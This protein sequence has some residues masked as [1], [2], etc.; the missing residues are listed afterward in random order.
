M[1]RIRQIEASAEELELKVHSVTS[2]GKRKFRIYSDLALSGNYF[3]TRGML[4][5]T[6]GFSETKMWLDGY[7]AAYYNLTEV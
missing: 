7:R 1:T 3:D 6:T 2:G 4:A 5:S